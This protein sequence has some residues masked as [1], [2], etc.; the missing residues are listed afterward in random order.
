MNP[1]F[2]SR[3][4]KIGT[5]QMF[6][7]LISQKCKCTWVCWI[8]IRE[9]TESRIRSKA[10]QTLRWY[11]SLWEFMKQTQLW[12]KALS[13]TIRAGWGW[14][15]RKIRSPQIRM[16]EMACRVWNLPKAVG[17]AANRVRYQDRG[18]LWV[19][20]LPRFCF[21]RVCLECH[22]EP[23]ELA[24]LEAKFPLIFWLRLEQK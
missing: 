20:V 4:K 1:E 15:W 10:S 24:R 17:S 2:V 6:K 16:K 7:I 11:E 9:E 23:Q 12:H 14:K 22:C 18:W 5:C 13:T 3:L 21:K 8:R 19:R